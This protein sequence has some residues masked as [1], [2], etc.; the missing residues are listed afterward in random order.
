MYT[1][2]YMY[3]YTHMYIHT[4]LYIHTYVAQKSLRDARI[5][6]THT[7]THIPRMPHLYERD[8][9]YYIIILTYDLGLRS[10]TYCTMHMQQHNKYPHY[11]ETH[12]P[13]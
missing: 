9:A 5:I 8:R 2:V 11:I 3:I 7:Y 12:T 1:H 6:D 13:L 10:G 4:Y